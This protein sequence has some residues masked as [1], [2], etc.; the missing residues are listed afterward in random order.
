MEQPVEA[1]YAEAERLLND[2]GPA[3]QPATW[4]PVPDSTQAQAGTDGS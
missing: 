3:Y 2:G 4:T 1:V